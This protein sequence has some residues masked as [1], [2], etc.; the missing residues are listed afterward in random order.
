[1][2]VRRFR[3]GS[4]CSVP[5]VI[6]RPIFGL[7]AAAGGVKAGGDGVGT[8]GATAVCEVN[9]VA[10]A[11]K[12]RDSSTPDDEP[13]KSVAGGGA[14]IPLNRESQSCE[15]EGAAVLPVAADVC[16]L[17]SVRGA[18]GDELPKL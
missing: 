3:I 15:A 4:S 6:A 12:S 16:K 18:D 17:D 2:A 9:F 5:A 11:L 13:G 1:M 7:S 10:G 14:E 8:T